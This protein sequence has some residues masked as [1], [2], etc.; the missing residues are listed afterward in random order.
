MR[1]PSGLRGDPFDDRLQ[2]RGEQFFEEHRS[3][4]SVAIENQCGGYHARGGP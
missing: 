4:A 2:I 1:R 3:D